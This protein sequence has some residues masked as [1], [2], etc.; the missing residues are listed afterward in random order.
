M[1]HRGRLFEVLRVSREHDAG[2]GYTPVGVYG[3]RTIVNLWARG[4]E[5]LHARL[6]ALRVP[7]PSAD[8]EPVSDLDYVELKLPRTELFIVRV[9]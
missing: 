3:P 2:I 4:N 5:E 1:T 7:N 9:V 8:D 6:M